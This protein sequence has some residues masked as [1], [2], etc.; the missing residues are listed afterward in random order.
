MRRSQAIAKPVTFVDHA[1]AVVKSIHE[2]LGNTWSFVLGAVLMLS[3]FGGLHHAFGDNEDHAEV[4][5]SVPDGISA[6]CHAKLLRAYYGETSADRYDEN[7]APKS[8][9]SNCGEIGTVR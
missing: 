5:S 3:I 4:V 6:E 7:G 1:F 2:T 9:A 8:D